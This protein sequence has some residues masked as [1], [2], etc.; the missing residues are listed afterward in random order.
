ME[1][2]V[3]GLQ[4]TLWGGGGGGGGL[5]WGD[6]HEADAAREGVQICGKSNMALMGAA[7]VEGGGRCVQHCWDICEERNMARTEAA[8]ADGLCKIA[9]TF[10]G[11]LYNA[12]AE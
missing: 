7:A 8:A 2:C 4:M 1:R 3:W 5:Q 12:D 6:K 9:G 11:E 10:L